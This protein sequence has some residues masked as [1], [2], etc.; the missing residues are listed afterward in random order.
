MR[1][2]Y[3]AVKS[4]Y[5]LPGKDYTALIIDSLTQLLRDGDIVVVSEKAVA[6]AEGNLVNEEHANP[7]FL[8]HVLARIWMR[9]VWGFLLGP[10]CHFRPETIKRLRKYPI[11]EG[12]HHK[13]VVIDHAGFLQAL[14]Y[15]SEGGID[16]NNLPYTYACLPLNNP[17]EEARSIR[18][19]LSRAT[20]KQVTLIIADTDSTFSAR[21]LHFTAR[22]HALKGITSLKGPLPMIIGRALRLKQ[23]ATPLAVVGS[24]LSVNEALRYSEIAHHARGYGAGRTVWD[25]AKKF[26]VGYSEVSWE[27][28]KNTSHYPI[29]LI[30]RAKS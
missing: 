27:M 14:N 3:Q 8:A 16:I 13:Q 22:P 28:L 12:S 6:T 5:W 18:D 24:K 23:Q 10:L 7:G 4:T 21:G 2:K 29:V 15:G 1:L 17:E 11:T 30:R 9:V 25:S 19:R 26:G 20:G